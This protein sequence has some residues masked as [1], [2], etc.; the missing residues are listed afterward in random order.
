MTLDSSTFEPVETVVE[1]PT[2]TETVETVVETVAEPVVEEVQAD[3]VPASPTEE[4]TEEVAEVAEP[5]QVAEIEAAPI[6]FDKD[7]DLS[8]TLEK[9][10]EVLG[11]YEI[12]E[13]VQAA[14]D[15]LKVKAETATVPEIVN[16]LMDY[17]DESKDVTKT[18]ENI[19]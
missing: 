18:V 2:S 13:E 4:T 12:P 5:E 8:S 6:V 16:Q 11:K 19:K 15:A 10:N 3:E 7:A 1:T 9:V 14:F 17:G